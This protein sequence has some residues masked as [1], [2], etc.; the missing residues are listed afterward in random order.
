M[1]GFTKEEFLTVLNWFK[2]LS[3]F[4]DISDESEGL[5]NKIRIQ[6]CMK[7]C[8]PDSFKSTTKGCTFCSICGHEKYE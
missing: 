4:V 7:F 8:N 6:Y 3:D 1:N 2:R 5:Y